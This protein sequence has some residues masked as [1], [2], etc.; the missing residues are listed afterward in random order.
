MRVRMGTEQTIVEVTIPSQPGYERVAAECSASFAGVSGLPADRV[1]D[2]RTAVAEACANA[3]EYGSGGCQ[4]ARVTVTLES[5]D[6]AVVA[7]VWDAGTGIREPLLHPSIE[8]KIQGLE[9]PKGWGLF[10]IRGLAD[11][12]DLNAAV[13]SG[14][15]IKMVFK[16]RER[17]SP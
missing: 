1:E 16:N 2:I 12:V 14:H 6:G 8:R 11:E 3:M 13:A 7:S 10:L 17:T 9:P 5:S 4:D 15:V